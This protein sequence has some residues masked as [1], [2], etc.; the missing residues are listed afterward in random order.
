MLKY[1][2][3]VEIVTYFRNDKRIFYLILSRKLHWKGYEF[4]KGG[5]KTKE[6]IDSAIKRE[7]KEETGQTAFNIKKY[8]VSGKYKYPKLLKDRPGV[9]GSTYKLASVELKNKK[10]KLDKLEHSSYKWVEYKQAL[11][12]LT[13]ST[14]RKCLRHV[15]RQLIKTK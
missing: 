11:K 7:I 9:I 6:S 1:R 15:N 8:P 5:I 14:Q 4:P 10:V 12:L 13:F 3:I 2:K